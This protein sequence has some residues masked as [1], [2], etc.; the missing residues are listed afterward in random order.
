MGAFKILADGVDF[1]SVWTGKVVSWL[2]LVL[3][4]S[5]SYDV[6]LRYLFNAPTNWSYT[7]SFMLGATMFALGQGY[8]ERFNAHARVDLLYA[9]FPPRTKLILDVIFC[10]IFF[11]PT[12]LMLSRSYWL[13]FSKA[14]THHEKAIEST[15]YPLTWPYK[16]MI[17]LGISLLFI[18]GLVNF[19]RNIQKLAGKGEPS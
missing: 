9:K 6:I 5:I 19:I 7:L 13:D 4:L 3:V 11:L 2:G 18:Q 16:L 12:F 15:W 8:V 17:A 10:A 14:L 1:I